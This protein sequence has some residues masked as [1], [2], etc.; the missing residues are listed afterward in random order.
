[1][2]EREGN[3]EKEDERW[4]ARGGRRMRAI[5]NGDNG[6]IGV[7]AC[8][9]FPEGLMGSWFHRQSSTQDS[10]RFTFTTYSQ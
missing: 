1:M 5:A 9:A 6:G 2:E 7:F 4:E 3:K 10:T 8:F